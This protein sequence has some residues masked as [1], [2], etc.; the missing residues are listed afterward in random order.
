LIR[1]RELN[2]KREGREGPLFLMKKRGRGGKGAMTFTI[3][4]S[5]TT[6]EKRQTCSRTLQPFTGLRGKKKKKKGRE[7]KRVALRVSI[8]NVTHE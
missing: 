6:K 3:L 8:P 1:V 5:S 4:A 2:C 7:R